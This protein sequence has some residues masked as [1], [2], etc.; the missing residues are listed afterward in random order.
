MLNDTLAWLRQTWPAVFTEPHKPLAIGS[1]RTIFAARPPEL[2]HKAV[3]RALY[4]HCGSNAYPEAII[5]SGL[6]RVGLDGS[7]A[8]EVT[9]EQRSL[10][11]QRLEKRMAKREEGGVTWHPTIWAAGSMI[12]RMWNGRASAASSS[13]N[14]RSPRCRGEVEL[15][16]LLVDIGNNHWI[17]F[18]PDKDG[19][20]IEVNAGCGESTIAKGHIACDPAAFRTFVGEAFEP[21]GDPN[22]DDKE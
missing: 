18:L 6:R 4:A 9:E 16:Y 12:Q 19:L 17:Y 1:G 2:S 7:D 20:R 11:R 13:Q 15:Y 8:G 3:K 21:I 10:A 5:R 22:P 14:G